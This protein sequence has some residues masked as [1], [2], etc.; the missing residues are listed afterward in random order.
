MQK[1]NWLTLSS[2]RTQDYTLDDISVIIPSAA[3]RYEKRWKFFWPQ[4][5][6][7]T[8]PKV[9]ENTYIPCD[10]EEVDILKSLTGGQAIV[11]PTSPRFIVHKTLSALEHITTRIT[12][13]LANDILIVREGWEELLLKQFNGEKNLQIIGELQQ[14]VSYPQ[15]IQRA[16]QLK[17]IC[18]VHVYLPR[19][20]FGEAITA[21]YDVIPRTSM[22][23]SFLLNSLE[24]MELRLQTSKELIYILPTAVSPTRISPQNI[25]MAI[26]PLDDEN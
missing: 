4:Y 8:H 6:A 3:G 15:S 21:S 24:G 14:G 16:P 5:V 17:S 20:V 22:M 1:H 13:R 19:P 2:R 11:V 7:K 23:N 26:L 18:T 25:L 10:E 9:V 12:I